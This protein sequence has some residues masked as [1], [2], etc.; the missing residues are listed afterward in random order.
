MSV[1]L[2]R[3]AWIDRRGLIRAVQQAAYRRIAMLAAEVADEAKRSM[4]RGGQLDVRTLRGRK[5]FV[6]VAV[7]SLPGTPPHVQTGTL[8]ASIAYADVTRPGGPPRYIVGPQAPP[9]WYGAV[10]EF[11]GRYHPPRPFMRP[12][13]LRVVPTMAS[14]LAGLDLRG[15]QAG[16]AVERAMEA[17][18]RRWGG[19]RTRG[20]GTVIGRLGLPLGMGS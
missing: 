3:E 18:M 11:G 1:I 17:W 2:R 9:A 5:R 19:R 7:P 10:H 6:R 16:Q 20:G 15:T 4:R 12:A 8:R 13:L 14:R